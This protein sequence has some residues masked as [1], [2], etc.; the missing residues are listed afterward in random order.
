MRERHPVGLAGVTREKGLTLGRVELPA[1]VRVVEIV[2]DAA[3][4]L[5]ELL[6]L[7]QAFFD[8]AGLGFG[9]LSQQIG[10]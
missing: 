9:H 8:T 10:T 3:Q 7:E 2:L 1:S 4:D 6:I 5:E